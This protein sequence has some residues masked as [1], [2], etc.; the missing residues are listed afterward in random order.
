M[1][2]KERRQMSVQDK[3]VLIT[4][5]T[6]GLGPTVAREAAAAGAYLAFTARRAEALRQLAQKNWPCPPSGCCCT[7]PT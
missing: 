3:V 7:P 1:H 4:G 2:N 6:G 5:A